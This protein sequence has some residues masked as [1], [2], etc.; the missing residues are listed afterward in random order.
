MRSSSEWNDTTTRRPPGLRMRSAAASAAT[1]SPSSSL[2]KMR[3]AW[4]VR[5][6]GMDIARA[7]THH[8]GDDIG[9]RPRGADRRL[10]ARLDD[11]ARDAARVALLAEDENDIG[12]IAFAR[13]GDHIGRAR[14]LAAHAHVERPVEAEREAA[15]GPIELHGGDAEVEH[16]AVDRVEAGAV[17]DAV[18]IGEAVFDQREPATRRLHQVGAKRDCRLVAVDADDF[19]VRGGEDGAG[20]AAGAE[21]GVDIDAA[22]V[23]VE[24]VDGGAAEHRNVGSASANDSRKA[25]AARG[26][27]PAPGASRA[28]GSGPNWAA[29]ER[30]VPGLPC[31]PRTLSGPPS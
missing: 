22:V 20:I 29:S 1:S 19:A 30:K 8:R 18:E 11:G 28:A 3:S 23:N 26:H 12:E 4:N 31:R 25:V 10:G 9:E 27:S 24:E 21:S 7:R 16:H 15:L 13:A 5:V 17:R 6:A 2:T 14:A